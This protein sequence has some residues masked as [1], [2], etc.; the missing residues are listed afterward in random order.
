MTNL[1]RVFPR[2]TRATPNDDWVYVG[3]PPLFLPDAD[4]VHISA[5]FTW[6]R[7]E[8]E[9]LGRAWE[10]TGLPVSV[11]GPAFDAP[12]RSSSRVVIFALGSLSPAEAAPITAGSAGCRKGKDHSASFQS[13]MAG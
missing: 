10:T 7:R 5:A 4:A 12:A 8:A 1:I 2:R 3:N 6:D 9:R 11:G 13:P